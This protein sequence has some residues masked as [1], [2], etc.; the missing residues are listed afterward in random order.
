MFCGDSKI[1]KGIYLSVLSIIKHTTEPLSIYLITASDKGEDKSAISGEFE[2]ALSDI[3]KKHSNEGFVKRFDISEIFFESYPTANSKTRFTEF[4][5]LRLYADKIDDIPDRILYL[6]YDVLCN[7]PFSKFYYQDITD[8][9]VVGVPDRYGKW[10][11]G[12]IFSHDYLNSGVLLLNMKN[13]KEN[14]TFEKCRRMC[15]SKKMFMP[16][17]SAINKLAIKRKAPKIYNEQKRTKPDTVFRH[18][19]TYFSLFPYFHSVTV[20]PTNPQDLH[21]RLKCF[22]FDDIINDFER[23]YKL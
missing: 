1:E 16:D 2:A 20:K 5:M 10:F 17:Q 9:D 8:V 15:Q 7:N 22:K 21:K 13:I 12:N 11:F 14:G 6:D 3:V 19:T 23:M 4:C 18:F